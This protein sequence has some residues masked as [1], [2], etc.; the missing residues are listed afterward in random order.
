MILFIIAIGAVVAQ[1]D[2]SYLQYDIPK[3]AK[4]IG[5]FNEPRLRATGYNY[6]IP[7]NDPSSP[8]LVGQELYLGKSLVSRTS[9]LNGKKHGI[10]R[11]WYSDGKLKIEEPYRNGL[12]NGTVKCWAE[13]GILVGQYEI[14]DGTGREISYYSN[15]HI[16]K[17][18][19]VRLTDCILSSEC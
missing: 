6:I 9:F 3:T 1:T 17:A 13:N 5:P 4:K 8:I 19:V 10:H 2:V 12:L 15:G 14:V 7:G 11:E 16:E 18:S